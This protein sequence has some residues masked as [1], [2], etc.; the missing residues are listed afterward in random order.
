MRKRSTFDMSHINSTSMKMGYI[1]PVMYQECLPGDT[2]QFDSKF[3]VRVAPLVAPVMHRVWIDCFTFFI[4]WRILW[5]NWEDF[6]TGG[7]DGMNA[8]VPPTISIKPEVGTL[9]DYLGLP[10]TAN[11]ISVSA[12]PF[13]AYAMIWNHF[14]RDQRLQEELPISLEDGVDTTTSTVLQSAAWQKDYFTTASPEPQLGPSVTLP[15]GTTAPLVATGRVASFTNMSTGNAVGLTVSPAIVAG[16]PIN[17]VTLG[18]AQPAEA[19]LSFGASGVPYDALEASLS[20]VTG[21]DVNQL[22]EAYSLQRWQEKRMLFGARYEDLLHF[23]GLRTQDARLQQP[24]FIASKHGTLQFSEVLQTSA[25]A[26]NDGVGALFGH[27]IGAMRTGR[28]RY[29]CWEHGLMMSF[30]IV[31]PQAVYTQGIER[32]W[33]RQTRYDYW[34]PEFQH[35]GQQEVYQKEVYADGTEADN[36]VFGYQNRYDEYRRGKNHVT[37]EF[38]TTLN[39][40]NMARE[41]ENAPSLNAEFITCNPTD[42]IY[43]LSAELSDQLYVMVQNDMI[44]KRLMSRHGNPI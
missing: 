34:N 21:V 36:N 5:N 15:I 30:L 38:R 35:I 33:S 4:P 14:F 1:V 29:Y 20:G 8:S 27:G 39:Y 23:W 3:F 24:E 43:Q 16:S 22:R 12:L 31:R 26:N 13:R 41:F 42:R 6:I 2:W 18:V 11:A 40:W 37:G 19:S 32:F 25:D 44:A 9:A 28:H 17:Q 10:L 7:E